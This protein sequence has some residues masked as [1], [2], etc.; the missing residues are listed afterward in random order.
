[1][2][3]SIKK[4]QTQVYKVLE[5]EGNSGLLG[6]LINAFLV[7]LITL[8]A[9]AVVLESVPEIALKY[10][11]FLHAFR[12][13]SIA[14]FTVEYLLRLWSCTHNKRHKGS[15]K[16]RLVFIFSPLALVDLLVLVQFYF[17]IATK[18]DLRFLRMLRFVHQFLFFRIVR[19]SEIVRTFVHVLDKRRIDVSI[20]IAVAVVLLVIFSSFMYFAEHEAQPEV[21]KDIPHTF[22]WG[23]VTLTTLG[24]GDAVPITPLGKVI[25]G[26]TGLFAIGTF[27][28]PPAILTFILVEEIQMLKDKSKKSKKCPHCGGE[29]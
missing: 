7:L 5:D 11:S 26:V 27:A 19:R 3:R 10:S 1:M 18:F 25:S 4:F 29:L 6:E 12:V 28:L 20:T 8:N 21:F 14:L 24:Y 13:F 16:G 9:V 23:I 17:G 22:W 2:K 15:I